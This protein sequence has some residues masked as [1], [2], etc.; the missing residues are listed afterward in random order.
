MSREY[1]KMREERMEGESK[2]G[3]KEED[4]DGS[5]VAISFCPPFPP[6]WLI[7][8]VRY[9]Y[10]IAHFCCLFVLLSQSFIEP[11]AESE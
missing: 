8:I 4:V 2:Q 3:R 9:E 10:P 6:F 5:E 7:F 1:R 11:R